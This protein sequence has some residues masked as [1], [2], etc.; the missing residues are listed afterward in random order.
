MYTRHIINTWI[1]HYDRSKQVGLLKKILSNTVFLLKFLGAVLGFIGLCIAIFLVLQKRQC[2][3]LLL[4]EMQTLL[5]LLQAQGFT[6]LKGETMYDFLKKVELKNENF[7]GLKKIN[8]LYHQ[9]RYYKKTQE[10]TALLREKIRS[11][12]K[13]ITNG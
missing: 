7:E 4:C 13:S 10:G 12:K 11:F 6:R 3:D 9:E 8:D 2:K 1:L 5:R